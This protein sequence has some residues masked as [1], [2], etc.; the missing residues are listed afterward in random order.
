ML[1]EAGADVNAIGGK[2]GYALQ[3]AAWNGH[4]LTCD[5]LIN[6]GAP[7]NAQG[8]MLGNALQAASYHGQTRVVEL[9]LE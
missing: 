6:E 5:A 9:L 1:L 3:A 8:G 4:D 2:F 7:V